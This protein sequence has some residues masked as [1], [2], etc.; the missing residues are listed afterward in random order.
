[1]YFISSFFLSLNVVFEEI[2]Y[3]LAILFDLFSILGN[4][5]IWKAYYGTFSKSLMFVTNKSCNGI[6]AQSSV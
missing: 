1:M 6:S 3:K 4:I 2:E 5:L